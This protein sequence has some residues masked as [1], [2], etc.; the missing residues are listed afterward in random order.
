[1]D[2]VEQETFATTTARAGRHNT[3]LAKPAVESITDSSWGRFHERDQRLYRALQA[4]FGEW[5]PD[6]ARDVVAAERGRL[7][8][9]AYADVVEAFRAHYKA[10]QHWEVQSEAL[11]LRQLREWA[12]TGEAGARA[13]YEVAEAAMQTFGAIA[14]WDLFNRVGGPDVVV[15]H[16]GGSGGDAA[17]K[18]AHITAGYELYGG[19]SWTP[20]LDRTVN[21]GKVITATVMPIR[22]VF[23]NWNTPC[24]DVADEHAGECEVAPRPP[25]VLHP[26]NSTAF[27]N[28]GSPRMQALLEHFASSR[29]P[30]GG[31]EFPTVT[32]AE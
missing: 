19:Y 18:R 31:H 10:D 4:R 14:R 30:R 7:D 24:S 5:T 20:F 22:I 16:G 28:D 8:D 3:S 1:V 2:W 32:G 13:R 15:F 12:A 21:Y 25:L 29:P 27:D 6:R 23:L 26:S 11:L 17:T 9:H